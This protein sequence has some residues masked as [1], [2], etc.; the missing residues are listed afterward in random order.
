MKSTRIRGALAGLLLAGAVLAQIAHP[1]RAAENVMPR[2][3]AL[4][5]DVQ[6]WIRV[7]TEVN[8]NS[9]FLHDE[10]NL[11]VVYETVHFGPSTSP[12]ERE[13]L[14]DAARDR[15]VAALKR[16][17]TSTDPL[18][19]D[20]QRIH[21]LW[22]DEAAP[23]RLLEA[24]NH[25]RFQL[26]Q[27]DRFRA[28][29]ERAGHWETHI[30][31]TLANLGLPSEL[32]VLP[33]VESSFNPAA[34]S[35]VGAAG[36]WQFMRSTGRRYM[37]I[38][39]TVDDRL[40]PFRSTEA[41]ALLLSYN[42]RLL[43]SWPLALTAYNHGAEGMRRA[44]EALGTDD[45]V[46][47]VRN[48]K[49]PTF[50]FASRNF[51]VSFLAALDVDHNPEKYFGPIEHSDEAKFQELQLPVRASISSLQ[52]AL[53][54]DA[55]KLRALNPALLPACW[56]GQRPV[57]SGY[58]LRLPLDGAKWSSD[59]LAQRLAPG[60][61]LV[62]V[63]H[64]PNRHRVLPGE[65]LASIAGQYGVSSRSLAALNGLSVKTRLRPGHYVRVPES[66]PTMVQ[67]AARSAAPAAVAT[68]VGSA[69]KP[70]A[71]AIL[72]T[73]PAP[74]QPVPSLAQAEPTEIPGVHVVQ[75]GESV[76]DIASNAG[77]SE[78]E[79]LALNGIRNP[80]YVFE[81]QQL[82]LTPTPPGTDEDAAETSAQN[83][84]AAQPPSAV[85]PPPPATGGVP[86]DVAAR[87]SEEDAEAVASVAKPAAHAEPVS[88]AQAE[89]LSPAVGAP[90]IESSE[91]ADPI[92]YSVGKDGSI[93]VA[94]TETLGH[95]ADWL[96]LPAARVRTVNHMRY[97]RPV[98]MG[99]KLKLDFAHVSREQF[100]QKR[101]EYHRTLEAEYFA[102]HR[103][104]GTEVYIARHGDSLWTVT[105][106]YE[107][108]PV[109]LLQQY[110]PDVDFSEMRAGTQLVVPRIEDVVAAG[111]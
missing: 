84:A 12:R 5:R 66:Q 107:H 87:E 96:G 98:L 65:T 95:Y 67:V 77:I 81:G 71:A 80:N 6:F 82:T 17:A 15:Y 48:Y 53:G 89:A 103:I 62:A 42:Y 24:T 10:N 101:R 33:H 11:A 4:E 32:A 36:L 91:T 1:L 30:A 35:K 54:I 104:S 83:A 29:L 43:G 63:T 61:D 110:N 2:P 3:A 55:E 16:I 72:A 76:S 8:T 78:S 28:G 27:S 97:G 79:L 109:W 60:G 94:A 111:G 31:E 73:A 49:S 52:R 57:P 102:A 100:E 70:I 69:P 9:G 18:S 37:R 38:D 74:A 59:L 99:H 34:Y 56:R 21:D 58:R 105:Q 92:D 44:K 86:A 88:A 39:S 85:S 14:V 93:V 26:G 41:A 7:Y 40:D 23:A 75:R 68:A 22:G 19:A 108:L 25:I 106:R 13:E 90:I 64:E 45:I 47:I 51:Y 20:D 50:G 46:Q